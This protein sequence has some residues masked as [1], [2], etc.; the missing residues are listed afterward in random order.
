MTGIN[1]LIA[2]STAIDVCDVCIWV[3]NG[4]RG[5]KGVRNQ[6]W[7]MDRKAKAGGGAFPGLLSVAV[8][9]HHDQKE[10]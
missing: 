8:I 1:S 5:L 4:Y 9:R 3:W 10:L 2:Y 6:T 7:V